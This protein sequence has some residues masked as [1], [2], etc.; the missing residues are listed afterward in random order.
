MYERPAAADLPEHHEKL[1][2]E[3]DLA[4]PPLG[5]GIAEHDQ[6]FAMLITKIWITGLSH[7]G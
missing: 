3:R 6:R 5:D 4:A 1:P 2:R 7:I